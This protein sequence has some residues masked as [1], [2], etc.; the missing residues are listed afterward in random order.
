MS[1][2][3]TASSVRVRQTAAVSVWLSFL[4]PHVLGVSLWWCGVSCAVWG[5]EVELAP[6]G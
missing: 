6:G 4:T 1:V 3:Y 5:L 2:R